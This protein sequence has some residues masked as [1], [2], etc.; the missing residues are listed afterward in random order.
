MITHS[1]KPSVTLI[2]Y[3]RVGSVLLNALRKNGYKVTAV[4]DPVTDA[5][6]SKKFA[7]VHFVPNIS[8][9]SALSDLIMI[10]VEDR[11]IPI[12]VEDLRVHSGFPQKAVVFH[13][14]GALSADILAPLRDKGASILAFHPLQTFRKGDRTD[15]LEGIAWVMDGDEDA[16]SLG[17]KVVADLRG[18]PI[19]INPEMR[20]HYHLGAVV[21][22]NLLVGLTKIAEEYFESAGMNP[23]QAITALDPLMKR[24][25]DNIV[26]SGIDNALTGPLVRG[27]NSTIKSHLK[28]LDNNDLVSEIYKKLSLY[29]I[30]NLK[31]ISERDEKD[32]L[33]SIFKSD[34][35]H[36]QSD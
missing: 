13:T 19:E 10:S 5:T 7:D 22:S 25:I 12:V 36:R 27:D 15:I 11:N 24:T 28:I 16:L 34:G 6:I 9:L 23:Q 8:G 31:S 1:E 26:T 20:S 30:A 4:V 18:H 29:L 17:H 14:A 35:R 32:V 21:A 3:G 2:G 33:M